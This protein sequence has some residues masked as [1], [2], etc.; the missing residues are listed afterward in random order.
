[1]SRNRILDDNALD[2]LFRT[3]RT[4]KAWTDREVSDVLVQAVYDLMKWGPTSGNCCPARF[5]F[6]KS[7]AAKERLKPHLDKGNVEKS[8]TASMT[9]IIAH[10]LKFYEKFPVLAPHMKDPVQ[11]FAGKDAE[12]A[13]TAFRNGSLQGAYFM[14]AAR[15][16]GLDCG[17]MSGFDKAGVSRE[18]FPDSDWEPNFLCNIGYGDD[19]KVFPRAPRLAFDDVCEIV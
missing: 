2:A 9:A 13:E 16:L 5:V 10:D 18:F 17:P 19:E 12:N 3:A 14:I 8:M 6:V 15:A 4:H 11:K 7:S 1:M